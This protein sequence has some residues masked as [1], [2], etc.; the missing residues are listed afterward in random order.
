VN[1]VRAASRWKR[2]AARR[3]LSDGHHSTDG[4][5]D[6]SDMSRSCSLEGRRDSGDVGRSMLDKG[7][8]PAPW[9]LAQV[10]SG[11]MQGKAANEDLKH[12]AS[13]PMSAVDN[14]KGGNSLPAQRRTTKPSSDSIVDFPDVTTR[15]SH[16]DHLSSGID[17]TNVETVSRVFGSASCGL[18][19]LITC[20]PF[21]FSSGI[22]KT[23]LGIC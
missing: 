8:S 12:A 15:Q 1:A 10:A 22:T 6:S 11:A 20:L 4:S 16:L 14:E 21:P 2:Y 5:L 17:D 7:I 3:T 9:A 19:W 13:F 18:T 23:R